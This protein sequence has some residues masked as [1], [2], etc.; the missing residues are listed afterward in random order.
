MASK[1]AEYASPAE[2]GSGV[3]CTGEQ[4][5]W[6]WSRVCHEPNESTGWRRVD[7]RVTGIMSE[8]KLTN[9]AIGSYACSTWYKRKINRV[10][11]Q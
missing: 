9:A 4:S 11:H 7:D 8:M 5:A 10:A 6:N 2:V 3:Y 1:W